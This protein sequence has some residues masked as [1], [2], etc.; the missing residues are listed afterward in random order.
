[1]TD[2]LLFTNLVQFEECDSPEPILKYMIYQ[3]YRITF[4]HEEAVVYTQRF[5]K[6]L[7]EEV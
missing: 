5:I 2:P 1:M 4:D 7:T 6:Q 3:Y